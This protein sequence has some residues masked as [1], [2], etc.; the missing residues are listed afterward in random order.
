MKLA[1]SSFSTRWDVRVRWACCSSRGASTSPAHGELNSCGEET[2]KRVSG[3]RGQVTNTHTHTPAHTHTHT[4][5]HTAR[6]NATA[7][8]HKRW[9]EEAIDGTSEQRGLSEE[10]EGITKGYGE[11]RGRGRGE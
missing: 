11:E 6:R 7:G 5:T 8:T 1:T 4:H 2:K 10:E 3:E 9:R